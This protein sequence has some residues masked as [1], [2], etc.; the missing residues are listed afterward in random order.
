MNGASEP[1]LRVLQ[2]GDA[3][4]AYKLSLEAGWNQTIQDW[5]MLIELSPDGCLGIDVDGDLVSTGTLFCYGRR[6]AWVGMVLTKVA[7]RGR[8]F[9]RR[10]LTELLRLA[11]RKAIETVKLD[12]TD[13]GQPLYEKLGFRVEQAVERWIRPGEKGARLK[14]NDA[15]QELQHGWHDLDTTAF[16]T[17][18]AFLL[19]RLARRR[20][21]IV[22]KNCFALSRTGRENNF[23]GP[24]VASSSGVARGLIQ[25]TLFAAQQGG[26][27]WD[28]FVENKNATALATELGFAPQRHLMR[29][30]R[31]ND[32][33][34][35]EAS[36]FALA[37][38]EVG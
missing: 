21:P 1:R 6:L 32:L 34:G 11:D 29:M 26:W 36:V 5:S 8:G 22:E 27:L 14:A 31:G 38:F 30:V 18:R 3:V 33:R 16:G 17:D 23:I 7:F 10:I 35:N 19:D 13:Q 25:S 2:A 28:L 9:A 4:S 24:C 12:A 20:A 15:G 37:G